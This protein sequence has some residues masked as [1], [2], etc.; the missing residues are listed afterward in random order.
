M[1]VLSLVYAIA[2]AIYATMAVVVILRNPKAVLNWH[3]GLVLVCFTIWTPYGVFHHLRPPIEPAQ[4]ELVYRIGKVGANWVTSVWLLFALALTSR[5]KYLRAWP[6]YIPILGIPLALS[7]REWY[8]PVVGPL[9]E[10]PNGWGSRWELSFWSVLYVVDYVTTALVGLYLVAKFGRHATQKRQRRQALVTFSSAAVTFVGGSL[11]DVVWPILKGSQVPE[12]AQIVG[13]SWAVGLFIT[14]TRYGL[15][16]FTVQ[17]AADKILATMPDVLLLLDTDGNIVTSN[18][19][20]VDVLG[21]DRRAL[22]GSSA[23][24]LFRRPDDFESLLVRLQREHHLPGLEAFV[25][26]RDGGQVPISIT[27]RTM[28]LGDGTLRGSVWVLRDVTA[29]HAAEQRQ[30]QLLAEVE[31]V[32]R[33]LNSFAYVVSHDLKAPLR[34]IDSLA[35]WLASDYKDKFDE[36]G[37]MQLN[38]LLGRVK[39]M[40]DLIDGILRYSRAGRAMEED[41]DVDLAILIPEVV[42]TLA[43]PDHISITLD[44]RFPVVRASRIKLEQVFQ[45]LLS[46]AIKYSNKPQ[47]L[48]RVSCNQEGGFWKFCVS[49]NGPGIEEKDRERVFELFQTLK[50]RDQS[51]S[52]GVGLAVVKKIVETYG[53]RIWVESVVGEGS[54]FFFTLPKTVEVPRAALT[55]PGESGSN[56]SEGRE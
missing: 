33:E 26:H 27:A 37:R 51:D 18:Q 43:P 16:S 34:A 47:G 6:I 50:P 14:V 42:E 11:F 48:V 17:A 40:H 54:R 13:L 3:C 29:R 36:E 15:T 38:L 53:G 35:K 41:V 10:G 30:A 19:A 21:H 45:N 22:H 31:G 12:M 8:G 9:V 25:R 23:A 39:R 2:T 44:C 55:G 49:D 24:G 52:T 56:G 28:T 7:I 20:L 1:T 4:A 32:N 5:Q 46:N